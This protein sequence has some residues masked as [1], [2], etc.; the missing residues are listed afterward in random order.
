MFV[1][2]VCGSLVDVRRCVLFVVCF[3]LVGCLVCVVPCALFVVC[4][5]LFVVG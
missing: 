3:V 1:F 5:V 2:V 4:R